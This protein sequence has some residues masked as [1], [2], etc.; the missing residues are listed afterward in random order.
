VAEAIQLVGSMKHTT[1]ASQA[2]QI[3]IAAG[4]PQ[5]MADRRAAVQMI[6]NLV[7]NA[8]KFTP[9]DGQIVVEG[10]RDDDGGLFICVADTGMGIAKSDIPKALAP[11]S[12]I[13]DG[14]SRHQGGTGLGLPI[15]KSL[16]ELH[17]GSLA[18]DSEPGKGTR[19]TLKFPREA[20]GAVAA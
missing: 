13:D 4:L 11:F 20:V 10:G 2:P 15:V 7:S 5:L 18:L 3:K 1:A 9:P 19:A 6:V 14:R 17:G 12:Q 8:V 16:I